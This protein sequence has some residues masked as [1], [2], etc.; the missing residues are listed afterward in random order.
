MTSPA[1]V[2][3]L[4]LPARTLA[5]ARDGAAARL[6]RAIC[7]AGLSQHEA[8]ALAGVDARQVRRWLSRE[9]SLGP[10][11][12]LVA[13]EAHSDSQRGRGATHPPSGALPSLSYCVDD[14]EREAA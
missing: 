11:E 7:A 12:L 13:L 10:L 4:P 1:K 5:T 6:R 8:G 14:V 9:V 2:V 3:P